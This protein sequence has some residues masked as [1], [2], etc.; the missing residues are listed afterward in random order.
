MDR[1]YRSFLQQETSFVNH[2]E[3][4]VLVYLENN[5]NG[6]E[7]ANTKQGIFFEFTLWVY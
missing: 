4:L 2:F 3:E 6:L 1:Q 7:N 5:G